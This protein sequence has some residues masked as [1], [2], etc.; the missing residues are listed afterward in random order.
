MITM[1][2]ATPT[3]EPAVGKPGL[4]VAAM[5]LAGIMATQVH[6]LG[7]LGAL[8]LLGPALIWRHRRDPATIAGIVIT[9]F[10]V[11][12]FLRR[13]AD[14][15]FGFTPSSQVLAAP[16]ASVGMVAFLVLR[17]APQLRREH[18]VPAMFSIAAIAYA[19]CLGVLNN[20]LFPASIGFL[21]F[22]AGPL[23]LLLLNLDR[24]R[25]SL[26]RLQ[27][28]L[29]GIAFVTAAY[30]IYQYAVFPPWEALWLL[31]TGLSGAGGRPEPFGIRTWS[32]LNS[33]APFSYFMAFSLVALSRTKWFF[34]L[35]PVCA[36]ALISTMGRSAWGTTLLGLG[37]A[38]LLLRSAD[39]SRLLGMLALLVLLVGSIGL[40]LPSEAL[41]RA[42]SRMQS[43]ANLDEDQSYNSRVMIAQSAGHLDGIQKPGGGGLG[44][45]GAAARVGESGGMAH[46]DNGF[47][48]LAFTF[49]WI[50]TML[51]FGGFFG[52]LAYALSKLGTMPAGGI[53]FLCASTALF[54]A[55]IFENTMSD[56]RGVLLWVAVGAAI[57]IR[58]SR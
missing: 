49:G 48:A 19:Y 18:L 44:S 55:N 11:S 23:L 26:R 21:Q 37:L 12:P 20:G 53:L 24:E 14:F 54:A 47:V 27:G 10:C 51:Y 56:F 25:F 35:G 8:A 16:Y 3:E 46:L 43:L 39:R 9:L 7:A 57:S 31:G 1:F 29:G 2:G 30:G 13:L 33:M 6:A 34:L 40:V 52:S 32:T 4:E 42:T 28:W 58:D 22:S 36:L 38:V 17:G 50:G 5:V 45:T 41:E 15:K